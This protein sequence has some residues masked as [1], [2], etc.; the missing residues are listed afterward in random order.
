MKKTIICY[1]MIII[2]SFGYSQINSVKSY[3]DTVNIV[4]KPTKPSEYN[5]GMLELYKFLGQKINYPAIAKNNDYQGKVLV[6]FVVDTI[7]NI[8]DA[9]V[10]NKGE[11]HES[12]EIEAVRVVKLLPKFIPAENNGRKVNS[13]LTIP[14]NFT[15]RGSIS[16]DR[17]IKDNVLEFTDDIKNYDVK[18]KLNQEIPLNKF[19]KE[20]LK[21]LNTSIHVGFDIHKTGATKSIYIIDSYRELSKE[22]KKKI[23]EV[24]KKV[25]WTPAVNLGREVNVRCTYSLRID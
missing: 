5:G 19:L 17:S 7:G 18:P 1:L 6:M 2:I 20:S 9:V 16:G 25:K 12:L 10:L 14:V 23:I 13:Y 3:K 11:C 15:I 4:E 22:E 21:G 24:F 8:H